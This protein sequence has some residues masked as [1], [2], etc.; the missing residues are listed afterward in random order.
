M[1]LYPNV[2]KKAREEIDRVIGTDRLP[3]FEDRENLPYIEAVLKEI[4]RWSPAVPLG[5]PHV[6]TEDDIFQ[7]YRIPKGAIILPNIW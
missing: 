2:Q 7:S 1:M 3:T 4:Q 6:T 5:V